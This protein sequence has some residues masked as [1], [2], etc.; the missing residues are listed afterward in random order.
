[1]MVRVERRKLSLALLALGGLLLAACFALPRIHGYELHCEPEGTADRIASG[2][3]WAVRGSRGAGSS[4]YNATDGTTLIVPGCGH[5]DAGL[6]M[7]VDGDLRWFGAEDDRLILSGRGVTGATTPLPTPPA[8]EGQGQEPLQLLDGTFE[9]RTLWGHAILQAAGLLAIACGLGLLRDASHSAPWSFPLAALVG[10][11]I[12]HLLWRDVDGLLIFFVGIPVL[13][14]A[15]GAVGLFGWIPFRERPR[16]RT[17]FLVVLAYAVAFWVTF[18]S[19]S[20][21]YP[22]AP[23]A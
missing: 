1:M 19:F 13:G 15:P 23:D 12:A 10:A 17:G 22:L 18:V 11:A 2:G 9:V 21:A 5:G 3:W 6:A 20:G 14:F 16:V 4:V 8:D 7:R